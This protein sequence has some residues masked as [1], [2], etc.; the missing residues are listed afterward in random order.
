MEQ[1]SANMPRPSCVG[2]AEIALSPHAVDCEDDW[3]ADEELMDEPDA[4]VPSSSSS[5]PPATGRNS[6]F[7]LSLSPSGLSQMLDVRPSPSS[8]SGAPTEAVVQSSSMM[9][10]LAVPDGR[11]DKDL[12]RVLCGEFGMAEGTASTIAAQK[13][14]A[15]AEEQDALGSFETF[16]FMTVGTATLATVAVS[17]PGISGW[18]RYE[19]VK[20]YDW[21]ADKAGRVESGCVFED[22]EFSFRGSGQG[23]VSCCPASSVSWKVTAGKAQR[24]IGLC[25]GKEGHA[26]QHFTLCVEP[27]NTL[28]VSSPDGWCHSSKTVEGDV[29][30]LR[31]NGN[32]VLLFKNGVKIASNCSPIMKGQILYAYASIGPDYQG[33]MCELAYTE[34]LVP[35][36]DGDHRRN[37]ALLLNEF[38]MINFNF[39][40][41]LVQNKWFISIFMLM[42]FYALFAP[43]LDMLFGDKGS[44]EGLA[45]ATS[46]VVVLFILELIVQCLGKENYFGR[47]FF[48]LDLVAM[49]SLL[50]DTLLYTWFMQTAFENENAFVAGRSSRL[51]R[52]IR[53]ASTSSKATRLNRLTRIIRVAS[54][55]PRLGALISHND[56]EQDVDKR[57]SKKLSRVFLVLDADLHGDV[58]LSA[59]RRC[60]ARIKNQGKEKP[61]P[62]HAD[63]KDMEFSASAPA[64]H[65]VASAPSYQRPSMLKARTMELPSSSTGR[66]NIRS[67]SAQMTEQQAEAFKRL[68]APNTGLG[69]AGTDDNSARRELDFKSK[70]TR[71]STVSLDSSVS[72][73]V[74]DKSNTMMRA[75]QSINSVMQSIHSSTP[76]TVMRS[77]QSVVSSVSF[78]PGECSWDD[79]ADNDPLETVED[80]SERVNFREFTELM[81]ADAKVNSRLRD[82]CQKQ[83][84]KSNNMKYMTTRHKEFIAVKVALG[85]L[86]LLFVLGLIEPEMLDTSHSRGLK[87]MT[88][89]V[90]SEFGYH[91]LHHKIPAVVHDQVNVWSTGRFDET[92]ERNVV[93]LDLAKKVYCNEF[94]HAG[95]VCASRD[96][97]AT[98]S[99]RTS[100]AWINSA[101]DN[102]NFRKRDLLPIVIPDLS[103]VDDISDAELESLTQSVAILYVRGRTQADAAFSV[104]TTILVIIIILV[105]IILL[106]KDLTI[107][108]KNLLKPLRDLADDMESIAQLELAGTAPVGNPEE[109]QEGTNEVRL[110]RHSFEAMKTAIRSWGKYVPWPVVH[111]LLRTNMEADR[112]VVNQ[113]VSLFFSDIAS[114]TTIVET[115]PPET[116]MLL[117][118][119]YFNEMSKVI[120]EHCG[121]VIEFIGDA[122]LSIYGTPQNVANH[123]ESAVKSAIKM[124][125]SINKINQW[126]NMTGIPFPEKVPSIKTRCGLHT[127]RVLVGNL[128]F[129][130]R[131]KYGIVGEEAHVPSK[132]EE[133]NKTYGTKMIVSHPLW[134]R[135]NTEDV[136]ITRPLDFVNLR[137]VPGASS[138]AIY[139]VIG[140]ERKVKKSHPLWQVSKLHSE[141]ME[142][143]RHGLFKEA[144]DGFARTAEAS[145]AIRGDDTDNPSV[146]MI[147]RCHRY[148]EKPPPDDWDG[149]WVP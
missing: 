118:S 94:V 54:L 1:G 101:V 131:M 72:T 24:N 75:S 74:A 60:I 93:Y 58:P 47:A 12:A 6:S 17:L 37:T 125:R 105:G 38:G 50:P 20:Y 4:G 140:L 33:E 87:H 139:E 149:T 76:S 28:E 111:M 113:E 95:G 124:Q 144:A 89:L 83:V 42:T 137:Q 119:H 8:A 80:A 18:A 16:H 27:D 45:M 97:N 51:M 122:I 31:Y 41:K 61:P 44:E 114:F 78:V 35:E 102:S 90:D 136:F 64:P 141:A 96:N 29:L 53:V 79:E 110:I 52:L 39:C 108:S 129:D 104:A 86:V 85:V 115:L 132:L 148:M 36:V 134:Q 43:D 48:W 100:I 107:L 14:A 143:Y 30:W 128:G 68:S 5:A 117:L 91:A 56:K 145:M 84:Y 15:K 116:S 103:A 40:T 142:L 62:V 2:S 69:V 99:M 67:N 55:M 120:D 46:V 123:A 147:K 81:L 34:E 106:T 49:L 26:R 82:A 109:L 3:A 112:K 121:I 77:I 21:L 7:Q 130:S 22:G 127:G 13:E 25:P 65:S 138:E 11:Y 135:L 98:W 133:M 19:D 23:V 66:S 71:P 88:K 10:T 146:I 63:Q 73:Q 59:V 126:A 92:P 9:S 70:A 32:E 57:L